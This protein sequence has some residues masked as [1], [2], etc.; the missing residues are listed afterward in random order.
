MRFSRGAYCL[1]NELKSRLFD[2]LGNK[3]KE[4][5]ES[6]EKEFLEK[7]DLH[8][9]KNNSTRRNYLENLYII[10]LLEDNLSLESS[11]REISILDIG[12]KNWF[13]ASGEWCFFKYNFLI[14]NH[15]Q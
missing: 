6:K 10:E 7:Y 4:T 14:D 3:E 8:K 12:S 13:Y 5:A 1:L 11:K 15:F 9:L 2:H